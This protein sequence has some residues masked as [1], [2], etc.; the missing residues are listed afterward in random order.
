VLLP[1]IGLLAVAGVQRVI[2]WRPRS[3]Y[4]LWTRAA[5]LV[6]P[7]L[8]TAGYATYNLRGIKQK[9]WDATPRAAAERA[10]NLV[11]W[12][13]EATHPG[14]L[15]ATDDDALVHLYTGRRTIPVGTFTPQE[16]LKEQT[17]AFA[18]IQLG[19]ILALYH[20]RYVM[21]STSY[22]VRSVQGLMRG[23]T[24]LRLVAVVKRGAIFEPVAAEERGAPPPITSG[25]S[26]LP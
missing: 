22:C 1:V 2:I 7:I 20:P 24:K 14:D 23:G 26:A 16:Y 15:L 8:L 10:T 4:A 18:T 3:R 19:N 6:L 9:W 11:E 17:Y 21:C 13:R 5:T 25:G 12:A